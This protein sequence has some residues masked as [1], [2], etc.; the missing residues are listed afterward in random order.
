MESGTVRYGN[1][2]ECIASLD[3]SKTTGRRMQGVS[4]DSD[5]YTAFALYLRIIGS[6]GSLRHYGEVD[7][8]GIRGRLERAHFLF[9][10]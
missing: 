3:P 2:Q 8:I 7:E 1:I 10:I 9:G 6:A 5:L 4:P